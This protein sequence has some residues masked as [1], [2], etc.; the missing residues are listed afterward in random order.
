MPP[1]QSP[2][3]TYGRSLPQP[4]QGEKYPYDGSHITSF[5]SRHGGDR[6]DWRNVL[7]LNKVG[8]AFDLEEGVGL[9]IPEYTKPFAAHPNG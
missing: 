7:K 6:S 3:L 4:A 8:S 2:L 1:N 9:I 5:I